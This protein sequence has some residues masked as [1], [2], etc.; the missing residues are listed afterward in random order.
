LD[1]PGS[2]LGD[3]AAVC[4]TILSKWC[5][6]LCPTEIAGLS[7]GGGFNIMAEPDFLS[8]FFMAP[9]FLVFILRKA[10]R[11]IDLKNKRFLNGKGCKKDLS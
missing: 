3:K 5:C 9:Y 7:F 6:G 4:T 2:E 1:T 8:R 10:S 11:I